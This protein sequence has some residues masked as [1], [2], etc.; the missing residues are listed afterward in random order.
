MAETG[1]LA[2]QVKLA[3]GKAAT[4]VGIVRNSGDEVVL[5]TEKPS[6]EIHFNYVP[7]LEFLYSVEREQKKV[8]MKRM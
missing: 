3:D 6:V 2:L 1:T 4:V 7:F 8:K 5:K